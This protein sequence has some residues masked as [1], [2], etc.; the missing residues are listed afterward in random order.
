M[1]ENT[2]LVI[3]INMT[4]TFLKSLSVIVIQH[5]EFCRHPL[6]FMEENDIWTSKFALNSSELMKWLNQ[7]YMYMNPEVEISG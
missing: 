4:L 1:T 5:V 2:P 7:R 3:L 6:N